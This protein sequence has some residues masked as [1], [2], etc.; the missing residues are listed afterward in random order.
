MMIEFSAYVEDGILRIPDAYRKKVDAKHVDIA[1]RVKKKRRA[2]YQ[3]E[4]LFVEHWQSMPTKVSG[5][6]NGTHGRWL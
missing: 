3:E 2:K 6:L 4:N 5:H 1:M